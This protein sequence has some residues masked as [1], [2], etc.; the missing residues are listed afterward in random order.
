MPQTGD[1]LIDAG[2]RVRSLR[3]ALE[4]GGSRLSAIPKLLLGLIESGE[5]QSFYVIRPTTGRILVRFDR[6]DDFV[7]S[8]DGLGNEL[9]RVRSL[10]VE[11]LAVLGQVE[12]LTQR[13][14]G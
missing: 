10:C 13:G 12:T 2:R 8:D 4:H 11:V 7:R 5:W 14:E 3:S 1:V 9:A 6:F